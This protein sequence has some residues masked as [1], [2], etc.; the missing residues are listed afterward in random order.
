MYYLILAIISST[1]ILVVFKLFN[2]WDIHTLQAI[3]INYLVAAAFGFL[4][5]SGDLRFSDIPVRPWFPISI[6][7]GLSLITGFNLYALSTQ[8]AGVAITA[9][10]GRVSLVIPVVLGFLIFKEP[11]GMLKLAGIIFALIA[12]FLSTIKGKTDL[13]DR[14]YL[15][16]PLLIFFANGINDSLLKTAQ[17]F[18]IRDDFVLFL[19]TSFL[20]CLIPGLLILMWFSRRKRTKL[21]W[22]TILAGAVLGILNWYSTLYALKGL[23]LFDASLFFPLLNIGIVALATI[24]GYLIFRERLSRVNLLGIL[25]A[26]VAILVLG[27]V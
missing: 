10:A 2:R 21:T 24:S 3:V 12:L 7:T 16:L 13:P 15:F 23:K 1:C 9:I 6:I 26:I 14:K 19:A 27:M 8:K 11:A 17:Y 25:I 5:G 4:Q 18:Y 22:K 20:V